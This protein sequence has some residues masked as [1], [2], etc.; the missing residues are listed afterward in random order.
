MGQN[1]FL[2]TQR[3]VVE[4]TEASARL[5]SCKFSPL[6]PMPFPSIGWFAVLGRENGNRLSGRSIAIQNCRQGTAKIKAFQRPAASGSKEV[7]IMCLVGC[8]FKHQKIDL[9][10]ARI[11]H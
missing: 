1:G 11:Y 8:D 7:F 4:G 10:S 3:Q 9:W 5:A 6:P 2:S